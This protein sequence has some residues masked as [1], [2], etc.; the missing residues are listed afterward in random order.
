[1]NNY[2]N[3]LL[4][5]LNKE[6]DL[7]EVSARV[8]DWRYKSNQR[9]ILDTGKPFEKRV[10]P[11]PFKGEPKSCYQNCFQLLGKKNLYYCEGFATH[12]SYPLAFA[13]AWLVNDTGEV[14]DPTW[15]DV[16]KFANSVYL[17]VAFNEEFVRE[18]ATK[19]Q[20]YGIIEN[21]FMID[22]KIKREGFPSHAL[23]S[24]FHPAVLR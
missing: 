5:L 13:H 8:V 7:I 17:G 14:I 21:D 24:K 11:T 15:W 19:T 9:L 1:M 12:N 6:A 16:A 18:I 3:N 2:F 10:E 20:K 22:H 4:S 23:S